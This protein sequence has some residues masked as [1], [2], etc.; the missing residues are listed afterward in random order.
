GRYDAMMSRLD[1][2]RPFLDD[3]RLLSV[4]EDRNFPRE[5]AAWRDRVHRAY[6]AA[7]EDARGKKEVAAVWGEDQYLLGLLGEGEDAADQ[8]KLEKGTLSRIVAYAC[9]E[10]LQQRASWLLASSWQEKAERAQA[11]ADA[12]QARG[13]P[14]QKARKAAHDAWLRA[15]GAWN[16]YLGRVS[17][18]PGV[19]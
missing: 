4:A 17:L 9:R 1:R 18:S 16:L 15:R 5:V 14:T 10:P 6:G 3:E 13:S 7:L 11:Q 12:E 8:K 19:L 2:V